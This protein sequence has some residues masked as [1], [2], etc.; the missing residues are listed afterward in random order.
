MNTARVIEL[1]IPQKDK[2]LTEID[3]RAEIDQWFKSKSELRIAETP[4]CHDPVPSL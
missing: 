3:I 2:P 1:A 4:V